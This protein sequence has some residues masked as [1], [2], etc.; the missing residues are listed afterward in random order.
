MSSGASI[1]VDHVI[2]FMA[3]G[4]IYLDGNITILFMPIFTA[5]TQSKAFFM[6]APSFAK[7][8]SVSFLPVKSSNLSKSLS[9]KAFFAGHFD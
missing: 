7:F 2:C 8:E 5:D 4:L 9:V 1:L 6:D 3:R